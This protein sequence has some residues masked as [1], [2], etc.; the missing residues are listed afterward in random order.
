MYKDR[1]C[2]LS[3]N[4]QLTYFWDNIKRKHE[5]IQFG[6]LGYLRPKD[7][8]DVLSKHFSPDEHV[9]TYHT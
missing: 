3:N 4:K 9:K 7:E 5:A 1:K 6:N 2:K 8:Y